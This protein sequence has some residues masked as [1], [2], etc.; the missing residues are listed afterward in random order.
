MIDC[1]VYRCVLNF[2]LPQHA[3]RRE[4]SR[5]ITNAVM[6]QLISSCTDCNDIIDMQSLDCASESVIIYR[7]RLEGTSQRDSGSL[8]SVIETWISSG[9]SF[10]VTELLMTVDS[11]CTVVIL[12]LSDH[13]DCTQSIT[14]TTTSSTT[15]NTIPDT[16]SN[17][18]P[19]S[20]SSSDSTSSDTAAII[21]GVVAVVI[22]I[23]IVIG[24][25]AI[26]A[27]IIK[28]RQTHGD[29]VINKQ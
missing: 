18:T 3:E 29:V 9:P 14:D 15:P 22:V 19:S 16:N 2:F 20:S 8:I 28:S 27:L 21:G 17:T 6:E 25:V 24:V 5:Q 4:A 13:G 10:I 12:S 7:A 26:V 23:V 11:Q 1:P